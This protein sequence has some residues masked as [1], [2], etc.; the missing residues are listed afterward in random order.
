M[1]VTI[2][3]FEF[4]NTYVGDANGNGNSGNGGSDSSKGAKTGDD[5]D[6]TAWCFVLGVT[7]L[8]MILFVIWRR[9]EQES[10]NL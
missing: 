5:A 4:D 10:K 1:D 8:L 2:A 3:T 9:R 6:L 7:M